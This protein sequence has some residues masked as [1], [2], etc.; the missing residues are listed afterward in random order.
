MA[1][2][3]GAAGSRSSFREGPETARAEAPQHRT[4]GAGSA[5]P[6]T[7]CTRTSH[8]HIARTPVKNTA[9][10]AQPGAHTQR[11]RLCRAVRTLTPLT[12][13]LS[14][15]HTH[16]HTHT[17]THTRSPRSSTR[18]PRLAH[19][20]ETRGHSAAAAAV[21][22][23]CRH[24]PAASPL[25]CATHG[26]TGTRTHG[27]TGTAPLPTRNFSRS[28][29]LL[30]HSCK[31]PRIV[32]DGEHTPLQPTHQRH[33]NGEKKTPPRPP[34][35]TLPRWGTAPGGTTSGSASSG[36][37][38]AIPAT[39]PNAQPRAPRCRCP[40]PLPTATA[41]APV[42]RGAPGP[43]AALTWMRPAL[44]SVPAPGALI[45][46]RL[47]RLL[48]AGTGLPPPPRLLRFV[49]HG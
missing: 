48:P 3:Q 44:R 30:S 38:N 20:P 14:L 46:R 7:H 27:H 28:H 2:P 23:S 19:R 4:G 45:Q 36:R 41:T 34:T 24:L 16:R 15:S 40:C 47:H 35:D 33:P 42:V 29:A 26:H 32:G 37:P 13:S 8:T 17:R 31:H 12:R 1:G 43:S 9:E 6:C 5:A 21:H 22:P 49:I 10:S 11:A 18:G 39:K 25:R